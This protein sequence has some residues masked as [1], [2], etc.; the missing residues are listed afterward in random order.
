LI[1]PIS[2]TLTLFLLPQDELVSFEMML[3]KEGRFDENVPISSVSFWVE[4]LINLP[5]YRPFL[6]DE[7]AK[8]CAKY[9]ENSSF[10]ANFIIESSKNCYILLYKLYL[11]GVIS[12]NE[13]ISVINFEDNPFLVFYFRCCF[14][15]SDSIVLYLKR[16]NFLNFLD[17]NDPKIDQMIEYGFP[18]SSFEYSIKYDDID[19]IISNFPNSNGKMH[20]VCSWSHFE[21]ALKPFSFDPLSF[22][23]YFGSIK[24]F[25]YLVINGLK[26]CSSVTKSSIFGG[27][28]DIFRLCFN[29][30]P[31][32]CNI[33]DSSMFC[34]HD[35]SSFLIEE[36]KANIVNESYFFFVIP[37]TKL[38]IEDIYVWW[39][40][41]SEKD[42]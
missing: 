30:Y 5:K 39:N 21:W 4:R 41:L 11:G 31:D 35:I 13:I 25:K 6:F 22:A 12:F 29:E 28:I 16:N 15:E 34:R 18:I 23:A 26:I 32:N 36:N 27:N 1:G 24:C 17:I 38:L 14:L 40:F 19:N 37:F 33:E 8:L 2:V 3:Y 9:C 7:A 20:S 10:K 42:F